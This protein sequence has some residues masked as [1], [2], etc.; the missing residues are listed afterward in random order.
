MCLTNVLLSWGT[1]TLVL[2]SYSVDRYMYISLCVTFVFLVVQVYRTRGEVKPCTYL[3]NSSYFRRH[4]DT[5]STT[6]MQRSKECCGYYSTIYHV[7]S[8]LVLRSYTHISLCLTVKKSVL[9]KS[10]IFLITC[11]F[12]VFEEVWTLNIS[13]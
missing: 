3:N 4:S 6:V 1:I 13:F 2:F 12:Q 8:Q 7:M 11:R 9:L 10:K 5:Y